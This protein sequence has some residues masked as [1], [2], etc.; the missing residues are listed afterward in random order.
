LVAP[1]LETV[2][3]A[4]ISGAGA[5][6][7]APTGSDAERRALIDIAVE[8]GEGTGELNIWK[9]ARQWKCSEGSTALRSDCAR[10]AS[11]VATAFA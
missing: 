7:S 5:T 3:R 8:F 2:W 9:N 10:F 1:S 6:G 11:F 4:D